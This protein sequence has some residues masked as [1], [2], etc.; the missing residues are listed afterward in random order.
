MNMNDIEKIHKA[1]LCHYKTDRTHPCVNFTFAVLA[2]A[3]PEKFK[4]IAEQIKTVEWGQSN[5]QRNGAHISK[6]F[7]KYFDLFG[8]Y[9]VSEPQNFDFCLINS[10]GGLRGDHCGFYLNGEIIHIDPKTCGLMVDPLNLV[11][12]V[13][14][15]RK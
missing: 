7:R 14:F 6:M 3:Y 10:M 1:S 5:N 2:Q 13:L 12:V 8:F 9:P 11:D 15:G 4:H